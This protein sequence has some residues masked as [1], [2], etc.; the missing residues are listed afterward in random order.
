MSKPFKMPTWNGMH[1]K[2]FLPAGVNPGNT[3][4]PVEG[5]AVTNAVP[6]VWTHVLGALTNWRLHLKTT[7]NGSLTA[8]IR[9]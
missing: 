8:L 5:T 7:G 6:L 4:S 2:C 3:A 1:A 9:S